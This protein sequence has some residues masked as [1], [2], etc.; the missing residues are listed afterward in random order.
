M[1]QKKLERYLPWL[2]VA[3]TFFLRIFRAKTLFPFTMDEE[4]QAFLVKQILEA[5]HFPLIG[6]NVADTGLYLG[7]FFTYLSA[8]PYALFG[9]SPIGGAILAAL[10][11]AATTW[12]IIKVGETINKPVGLLAG[13]FYAVSFLANSYDRKFWNPSLMLF[14]AVLLIFS[15]LNIRHNRRWLLVVIGVF[16]MAFHTHYALLALLPVTIGFLLKEKIKVSRLELKRGMLILAIFLLPLIVFDLRHNFTNTRAGLNL[17]TFTNVS[18]NRTQDL[19][20]GSLLLRQTL[21]RL[22]YVPGQHDLA[23]EIVW[24]DQAVR[25]KPLLPVSLLIIL[26]FIILSQTIKKSSSKKLF[27]LLVFSFI[28]FGLIWFV[29]PGK[30]SEYYLLPLFPITYLTL[31]WAFETGMEKAKP[32]IKGILAGGVVLL[33]IYNTW[34]VI[35]MKNSFGLKKKEQLIAWTANQVGESSYSLESLGTCHTFEGYRYL[36]EAYYKIP[37]SSY[38]DSYFS[39]LYPEE[40]REGEQIEK[41]VIVWNDLGEADETAR[42]I[43]QEEQTKAADNIIA[44]FGE[45][46]VLIKDK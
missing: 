36:F 20:T 30:M 22:I 21:D 5:R 18:F 42:E 9:P 23:Q 7:P 31:A 37:A 13:L 6:V 3:L 15:L 12:L 29:Y 34:S 32:I 11:G 8:I 25:S 26:A 40:E 17:I 33:V 16:G 45:I 14:L 43:W 39:W 1:K 35:D 2:I 44:S 38:M 46:K 19:G 4:Y 41:E 28:S 27:F 10:I 24:C